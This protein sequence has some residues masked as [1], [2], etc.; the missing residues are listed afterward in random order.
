MHLLMSD[1]HDS[2]P[3]IDAEHQDI[4]I[5]TGATRG[6]GRAIAER[7]LQINARVRIFNLGRSGEDEVK[8]NLEKEEATD[9]FHEV[10]DGRRIHFL[11]GVDLADEEVV[12]REISALMDT[13]RGKVRLVGVIHCAGEAVLCDDYESADQSTRSRV[14]SM[15]KVNGEFPVQLARE[16]LKEDLL[17]E[18]TPFMYVSS[19][20]A[21]PGR[22]GVPGL[23]EY[24]ATK[25]SAKA[26]LDALL[27]DKKVPVSQV[28]P[29]I[30]NTGMV[31]PDGG[32]RADGFITDMRTGLEFYGIAAA[33]AVPNDGLMKK[34]AREIFK[35]KDVAREIARPI[36]PA[37][38]VRNF[39]T[40]NGRRFALPWF[41]K[42]FGKQ[43]LQTVGQGEDEHNARVANH[44]SN[45]AYGEDFPYD[46]VTYKKLWPAWISKGITKIGRMFGLV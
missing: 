32:G 8:E 42:L 38:Y 2:H 22:V 45:N 23:R 19:L 10:F 20:G 46:A 25:E 6:I 40:E 27:A 15:R 4:V 3:H 28:Y 12:R 13:I 17:N 9:Q 31:F 24:A 29:G 11:K 16:L 5:M 18:D 39:N 26:Q 35:G 41:V 37:W 21:Y 1:K 33:D 44:E 36:V 30:Y 7:I 34:V 43:M 14:D